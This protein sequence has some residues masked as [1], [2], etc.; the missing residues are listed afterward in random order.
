[1][2]LQALPVLLALALP[3]QAAEL[4]RECVN[5]TPQE[6]ADP[7]IQEECKL[8]MDTDVLLQELR[9]TMDATKSLG[10]KLNEEFDQFEKMTDEKL[11]NL[12]LPPERPR[13]DRIPSRPGQRD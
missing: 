10:E 5:P 2:R 8:I 13:P 9:K 12:P 11:K 7:A 4:P 6:K 1:M 3:A